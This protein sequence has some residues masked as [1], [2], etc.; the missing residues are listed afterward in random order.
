MDM[1][2]EYAFKLHIKK[3]E[4]FKAQKYEPDEQL[5]QKDRELYDKLNQLKH[6]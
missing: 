3:S 5:K 2:E 1:L 4:K 6:Y